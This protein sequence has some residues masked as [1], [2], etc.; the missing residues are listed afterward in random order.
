MIIQSRHQKITKEQ[1]M[2]IWHKWVFFVK[3]GPED[4]FECILDAEDVELVREYIEGCYFNFLSSD[5]KVYIFK[6]RNVI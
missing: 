3:P 6:K 1:F 5:G 4:I 2:D